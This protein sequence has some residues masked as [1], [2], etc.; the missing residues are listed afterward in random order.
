MLPL[1]LAA[2]FIPKHHEQ[3]WPRVM[4]GWV[5]ITTS[6]VSSGFNMLMCFVNDQNGK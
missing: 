5:H 3:F 2:G 6:G 4:H 1:L